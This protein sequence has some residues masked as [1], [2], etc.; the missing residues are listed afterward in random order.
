MCLSKDVCV[1]GLGAL[2]RDMIGNE[3]LDMAERCCQQAHVGTPW[4]TRG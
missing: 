1:G 2:I 4:L 3:M